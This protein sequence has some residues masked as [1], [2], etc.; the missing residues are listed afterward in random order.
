[1]LRPEDRVCKEAP[2]LCGYVCGRSQVPLKELTINE[3]GSHVTFLVPMLLP[4][5]VIKNTFFL[6][7]PPFLFIEYKGF[8]CKKNTQTEGMTLWTYDAPNLIFWKGF[9]FVL[10]DTTRQVRQQSQPAR[11]KDFM[12]I[13]LPICFY[14]FSPKYNLSLDYMYKKYTILSLKT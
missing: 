10:T 8:G 4:L 3:A 7:F 2:F 5:G 1:M 12:R 6:I 9:F 14:K 11:G 13:P